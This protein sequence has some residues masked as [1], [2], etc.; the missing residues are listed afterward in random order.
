MNGERTRDEFQIVLARDT[1]VVVARHRKAAGAVEREVILAV[2]RRLR[3]VGFRI[4]VHVGFSVRY[5]IR[6]AFLERDDGLLRALY[7]DRCTVGIRDLG[8][9]QHQMNESV[10]LHV[11]KNLTIG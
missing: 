6:R 8:A 10:S 1:V 4:R 9:I 11:H 2:D 3:L 7:K 5:T